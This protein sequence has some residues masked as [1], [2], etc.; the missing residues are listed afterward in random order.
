MD[1]KTILQ[2]A[3]KE[4]GIDLTEEMVNQFMLYKDLLI[5]WNEKINLTSI[6]DEK[7]IMLKHFADCLSILPY[8]DFNENTKIID[9][10]TGAGFPAVPVKISYP[11]LQVTLLDS[12]Q[13]RI[14]FLEELVNQ[15]QLDDVD[16]I[17][18]RAED[19]GKD[20]DL[21]EN[22]DYCVARAVANLEVLAEYTLPFVKIGG[23]LIALKGRDAENEIK[24]GEEMV[25]KL[26]GKITDVIDVVI[27]FT[28]LEHKLIII[29][30]FAE[31]PKNYPRKP[32][33]IKNNRK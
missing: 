19:G 20:L 31:T 33:Q 30:K 5:E 13:K 17:H 28:D 8:C 2:N 6:T 4:M 27:P 23:K 24:D 12:L 9:V 22:F 26:G 16:C 10:G 18:S 25:T 3:C 32:K 14:T 29:E 15:L 21:R 7:E 1:N 11:T